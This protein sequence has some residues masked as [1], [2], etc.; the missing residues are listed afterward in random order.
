MGFCEAVAGP[1]RS[2]ASRRIRCFVYLVAELIDLSTLWLSDTAAP[3]V[4]NA[5]WF[6]S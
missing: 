4:W 2:E 3:A 5:V 6:N 1:V